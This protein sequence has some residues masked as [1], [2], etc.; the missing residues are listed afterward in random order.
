[1][2]SDHLLNLSSSFSCSATQ[3]STFTLQRPLSK[4]CDDEDDCNS[5]FSG[6]GYDVYDGNGVDGDNIEKSIAEYSA[7]SRSFSLPKRTVSFLYFTFSI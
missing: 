3:F 2:I 6:S 1:M 5:S 7:I 4:E